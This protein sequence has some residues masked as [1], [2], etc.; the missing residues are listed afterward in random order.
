MLGL[1]WI[2]YNMIQYVILHTV[3]LQIPRLRF[4][5]WV[6]IDHKATAS[7]CKSLGLG[8]SAD[9]RSSW[10]MQVAMHQ[11]ILKALKECFRVS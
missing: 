2:A 1:H 4:N 9:A 11:A 3:F 6:T 7:C 8:E 5:L 10:L